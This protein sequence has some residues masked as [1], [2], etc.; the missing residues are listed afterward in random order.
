MFHAVKRAQ[1]ID[2]QAASR[3][4][5]PRR[6]GGH[7]PA[8]RRTTAIMPLREGGEAREGF[9]LQMEFILPEQFFGKLRAY[10]SA[11]RRL[12]A[13]ILEDAIGCFQRFLFASGP[14]QRRLHRDAARWI[15]ERTPAVAG[16]DVCPYFSFDRVCD[17]LG[18]DAEGVRDRLV[19]WRDGQAATARSPRTT[20]TPWSEPAVTAV[21]AECRTAGRPYAA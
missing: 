12:L 16:D 15:M 11:E 4:D 1:R 3:G 21:S 8:P 6:Q 18:L 19:R 5:R 9:P 7:M 20:R 2:M 14:Q 17:V 10:E 13:A